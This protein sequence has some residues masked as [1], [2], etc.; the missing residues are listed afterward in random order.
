MD[1]HLRGN[2]GKVGSATFPDAQHLGRSDSKKPK[3]RSYDLFI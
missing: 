3:I 1:S 2:D